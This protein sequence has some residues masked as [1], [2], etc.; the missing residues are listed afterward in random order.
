MEF[1]PLGSQS[2]SYTLHGFLL[3]SS[4][5]QLILPNSWVSSEH[6][7][8]RQNIEL[9]KMLQKTDSSYDVLDHITTTT[10][11]WSQP[12]V[13]IHTWLP[14]EVKSQIMRAMFGSTQYQTFANYQAPW[15]SNKSKTTI[16]D[17]HAYYLVVSLSTSAHSHFPPI[18]ATKLT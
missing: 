6:F 1:P 4:P 15:S 18:Y 10:Q 5:K 17:S 3:S 16:W 11:I 14:T 9:P 2:D 7:P 8:V 13:P 12:I